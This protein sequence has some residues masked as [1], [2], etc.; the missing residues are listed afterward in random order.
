MIPGPKPVE[1]VRL[2]AT[3]NPFMGGSTIAFALGHAEDVTL[4]VYDLTGRLVRSLQRC[5][6]ADGAYRFEWNGRDA[7]GRRVPAGV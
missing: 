2:L 4:G 1:S 6:L 7:N 5:R 3:P